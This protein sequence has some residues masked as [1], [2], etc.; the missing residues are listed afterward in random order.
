ME[1]KTVELV[2]SKHT[3]ASLCR[4]ALGTLP[5]GQGCTVAQMRTRIKLLDTLELAGDTIEMSKEEATEMLSILNNF[6]WAVVD[7]QIIEFVDAV[8]AMTK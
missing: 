6:Q 8:E 5:I 4:T 2:G 3:Y 1:N 7:R